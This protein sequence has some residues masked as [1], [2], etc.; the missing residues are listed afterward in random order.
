MKITLTLEQPIFA[1]KRIL[2]IVRPI[3][4]QFY[5][6]LFG[7]SAHCGLV[8]TTFCIRGRPDFSKIFQVVWD[9]KCV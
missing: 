3:S 2:T 8:V 7:E 1:F 4:T 9:I 5:K 6:Q